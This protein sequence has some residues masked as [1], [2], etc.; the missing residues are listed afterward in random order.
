MLNSIRYLVHHKSHINLDQPVPTIES[1]AGCIGVANRA[2]QSDLTQWA[3][4]CI[5][6]NVKVGGLLVLAFLPCNAFVKSFVYSAVKQFNYHNHNTLVILSKN[7]GLS[8]SL[9]SFALLLDVTATTLALSPLT[10]SNTLAKSLQINQIHQQGA[11]SKGAKPAESM[12]KKSTTTT[13]VYV[14]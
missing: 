2:L 4:M 5:V 9:T 12:A 6:C 8:V 10:H 14:T 1:S 7:P 13:V 3:F 11:I